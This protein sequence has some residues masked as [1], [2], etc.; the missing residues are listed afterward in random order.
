MER[1]Q[2]ALEL[3]I[4]DGLPNMGWIAVALSVISKAVSCDSNKDDA[5]VAQHITLIQRR[6][7]G[8]V[9]RKPLENYVLPMAYNMYKVADLYIYIMI[10]YIYIYG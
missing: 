5:L 3:G 10:I 9:L 8:I 2:S 6:N 1:H 7:S 4:K